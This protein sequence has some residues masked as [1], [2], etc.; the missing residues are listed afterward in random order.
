MCGIYGYVGKPKNK[1]MVLEFT[2]ALMYHTQVR[3]KHS[4]GYFAVTQN[5][6]VLEKDALPAEKFLTRSQL[7]K[8]I[9]KEKAYVLIG[10]NRWASVGDITQE[11][12]HPFEGSRFVLTHN[13][14]C[15][16]ALS[17]AKNLKLHKKMKGETDSEAIL[18]L[19]EH[20]GLSG[21]L[22]IL[23]SLEDFSIVVFDKRGEEIF[24]ARNDSKPLF[25]V[26]LRKKLGIRAWASTVGIMAAALEEVGIDTSDVIGFSTKPGYV[27]RIDNKTL[28]VERTEPFHTK[29]KFVYPKHVVYTGSGG[30]VDG[31]E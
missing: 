4:T 14:T 28:E 25:I 12:A 19:L 13:G 9:V 20:A 27:Y 1:K 16:S 24:F 6:F 10:H 8:V 31:N 11:N 7:R 2:E 3:G 23:S 15:S 21:F 18:M 29:P 22:N 26:D 5:E 17:K 30:W